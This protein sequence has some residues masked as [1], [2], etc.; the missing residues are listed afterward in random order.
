MLSLIH[1]QMCI[2][3]RVVRAWSSQNNTA[4]N[5]AAWKAESRNWGIHFNLAKLKAE[6]QELAQQ[7]TAPDF[8][9]DAQ[10]SQKILKKTKQLKEKVTSYESLVKEHE[11]LRCV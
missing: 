10:N 7:S 2:R 4:W 9:E 8:W 11:D 5:C 6:I 1:I 3:D